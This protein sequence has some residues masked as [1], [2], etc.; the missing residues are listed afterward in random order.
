MTSPNISEREQTIL[1]LLCEDSSATVTDISGR[2]E[3][4]PV[5]VRS[6]LAGLAEKGLIVRTHGGAFP[7]FHPSIT[8]RQRDNLKAKARIAKAAAALVRDGD[9]IMIEAGTTTALVAKYLLGKRDVHVVTNSTLII[10]HAR[11]NPGM[12][13]TVVG[14]EFRPATESMVGPV[15]LRDLEQFHVRLAFIGTDGFSLESGLTTHLVEGAEIVRKMAAQ[16]EKTVLV[17]DST[18]Y[19]KIGFARVL[20]VASVHQVITDSDMKPEAIRELQEAGPAI[21]AV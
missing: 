21:V 13:L 18:K 15:A 16:A 2:L 12:H 7:A 8:T 14:G 19:G 5:T 17:A 9:T 4:S 6:D 11:F 20:P 3:V 10:P 1:E